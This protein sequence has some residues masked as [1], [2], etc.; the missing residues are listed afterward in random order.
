MLMILKLLK[1]KKKKQDKGLKC[2]AWEDFVVCKVIGG[3][4]WGWV[5]GEGCTVGQNHGAQYLN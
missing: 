2:S 4:G 1:V 3:V 5:E